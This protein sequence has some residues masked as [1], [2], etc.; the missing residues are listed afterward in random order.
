MSRVKRTPYIVIH[1][2]VLLFLVTLSNQYAIA[3]TS[4]TIYGRLDDNVEYISGLTNGVGASADRLRVANSEWR[5]SKLGFTGTEDIAPDLSSFFKLEMGL[6]PNT[7]VAG[8]P[9]GQ[10]FNK[11]AIVGL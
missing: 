2:L 7:G 11:Y 6:S 5:T 9:E 10:L 8:K 4:F 3:Q 1:Y